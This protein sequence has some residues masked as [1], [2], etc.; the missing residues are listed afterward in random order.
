MKVGIVGCGQIADAHIQSV[1]RIKEATT[2]AVCDLSIHLAEQAAK[3]FGIENFYTDIKQMIQE[4]KPD[5]IHITTPPNTH[6]SLA[7]QILEHS[8][9]IY[10]EKPFTTN[11]EEAEEI[12]DMAKKKGVQI[13]AGHSS[14]FDPS[15]LKLVKI[16]EQGKLGE[17][18]HVNA[19]MGY[20]LGGPFGKVMMGEPNHWVFDLPGGIPQNNISHPVSLILG[21]MKDENIQ[22]FARG[23]RFRE[24]RYND[25][26]DV[27]F[28]ELRISMFGEKT[29]AN[30]VFSAT[31]RP[32]E[33]YI[34][35][36]G[37]KSIAHMNFNS[38][39]VVQ[40]SGA[41]LPGPFEKVQWARNY[42]KS[43]KKEYK[44]NLGKLFKS[45]IHY[46]DGM[47]NLIEKFYDSV[48]T[49]NDM[50]LS[51]NEALRATKVIDDIFKNINK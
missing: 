44:E 37:T 30:I 25:K 6:Y 39:S 5:V 50:P 49:G 13:C 41:S 18:V 43:A 34:D 26:R 14:A 9:H 23:F 22:V 45:D 17:L 27:F 38:R 24:E 15:Y 2:V 48:K 31:I 42:Y 8:I 32:L 11:F 16:F 36:Y 19:G 4:Q 47:K 51:M 3:R 40:D 35:V 10:M 20:G 28:D 33:L 1:A 46:F 7:K 12:V 29:S 21:L